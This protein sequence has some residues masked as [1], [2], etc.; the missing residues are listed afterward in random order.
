[1][2]QGGI[3]YRDAMQVVDRLQIRPVVDVTDSE[4]LAAG[5]DKVRSSKVCGKV[6]LWFKCSS[7]KNDDNRG[8]IFIERNIKDGKTDNLL[9]FPRYSAS[10]NNVASALSDDANSTFG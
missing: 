4:T 7:T 3:L 8:F 5:I 10:R 1:M 2:M 9:H 6:L